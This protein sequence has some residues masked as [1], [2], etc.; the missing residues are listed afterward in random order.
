MDMLMYDC[1]RCILLCPRCYFE[2]QKT[3]ADGMPQ[4]YWALDHTCSDPSTVYHADPK[5]CMCSH[6]DLASNR[7]W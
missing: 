1:C 7:Y 3:G 2:L 4:T 6:F 5:T